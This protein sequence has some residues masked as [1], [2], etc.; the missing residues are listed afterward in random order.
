[1][2]EEDL[3]IVN[4]KGMYCPRGKFYID[5]MT[6]VKTALITHGHSDHL[7]SGHNIYYTASSGMRIVDHRIQQET[8]YKLNSVEFDDSFEL[9]GVTI[10]F[11]PAG[12]ILGSAQI[13]L[14]YKGEVW[15]ISGDY[16]REKD[17]TC[18]E[19]QLQK[20]DVFISEGTFG[21][22]IYRWE[23]GEVVGKEI[24]DWWQ[25][26]AEDGK[27]SV[28][29]G[30]VLGKTQ[31]LLGELKKHTDRTIFLHGA[32]DKMTEIYRLEGI[33]LPQRRQSAYQH[34]FYYPIK[35]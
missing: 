30:Y 32:L 10:S 18:K 8:E 28:I 29:Y 3:L 13:R 33:E 7:I 2:V 4:S 24:F 11:H 20:C 16:K 21:L 5:P 19:F 14:E 6:I 27:S 25:R 31:R 17:P 22:P 1:V 23:P 26:N 35:Q 9:N 12:H 34:N 15:V